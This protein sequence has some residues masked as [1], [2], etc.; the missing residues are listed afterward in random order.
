MRSMYD[1]GF[2]CVD[3][4]ISKIEDLYSWEDCSQTFEEYYQEKYNLWDFTEED[5]FS[6]YREI[7]ECNPEEVAREMEHVEEFLIN[8]KHSRKNRFKIAISNQFHTFNA[9]QFFTCFEELPSE[10][11]ADIIEFLYGAE[12]KLM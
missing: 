5:F 9:Y 3:A 7:Y 11:L 2:D 8:M 12:N 10:T 4:S 1:L 6:W